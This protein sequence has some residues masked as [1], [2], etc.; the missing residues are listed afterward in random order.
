[1]LPVCSLSFRSED[2]LSFFI[3]TKGSTRRSRGMFLLPGTERGRVII[4][5]FL[6]RL[7]LVTRVSSS[8]G[9]LF[10]R[11]SPV[12]QECGR[13]S[14]LCSRPWG[15]VWN[16]PGPGYEVPGAL[17]CPEK[18]LRVSGGALMFSA[19]WLPSPSGGGAVQSSCPAK[20]QD[21]VSPHIQTLLYSQGVNGSLLKELIRCSFDFF[22]F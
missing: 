11:G 14:A 2:A 10:L 8:Q 1:M 15:G 3:P 22:S 5:A 18:F 9:L 13:H 12:L 19:R 6:G 21:L 7:G 17:I 16:T 4:P 20:N